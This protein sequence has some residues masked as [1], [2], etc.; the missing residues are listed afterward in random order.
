MFKDLIDSK[1]SPVLFVRGLV[2]EQ[3]TS[4]IICKLFCNFGNVIRLLYF[5]KRSS[6]LVEFE[7]GELATIAKE[8]LNNLCFFGS[9]LKV[10]RNAIC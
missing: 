5:K 2:D 10:R 7:S 9:L 3:M 8:M 4:E 1:S 6:A